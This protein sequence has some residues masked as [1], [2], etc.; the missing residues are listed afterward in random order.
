MEQAVIGV[1]MPIYEYQC[2]KCQR[3]FE[4]WVKASDAHGQE[5]CPDCG[6]PSPRII[7]QTSFVL[8]GGGWYVSDYGYRKG[9]SEDGG[10]PA[11]SASDAS[12]GEAKPAEEKSAPAEKTVAKATPP[13]QAAKAKGGAAAS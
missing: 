10:A 11:G 1:I 7:S 3:V 12:A 5:P 9:I 2:P 6:T 13:S 4:E 8:K